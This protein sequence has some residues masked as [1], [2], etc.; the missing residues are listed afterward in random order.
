VPV[1]VLTPFL[2]PALLYEWVIYKPF[3]RKKQP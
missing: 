2:W 1:V 3:H